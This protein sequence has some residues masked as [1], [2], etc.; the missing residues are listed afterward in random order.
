M[1]RY[2]AEY[3]VK[4]RNTDR[5]FQTQKSSWV[6]LLTVK[7]IGVKLL[8]C[9]VQTWEPSLDL[10]HPSEC[11]PHQVNVHACFF[12]MSLIF[13]LKKWSEENFLTSSLWDER[14]GYVNGWCCECLA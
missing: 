1:G 10:L 7:F 6:S 9:L 14:R 4:I 12:W 2:L 13:Q 3:V 5:Y 8:F 11:F